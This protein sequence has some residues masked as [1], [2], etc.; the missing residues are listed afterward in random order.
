MTESCPLDLP[1]CF[2][3]KIFSGTASK[4]LA[5]EVAALLGV[6]V[7]QAIVSQ[8]ADGETNIQILQSVRG[9]DCYVIQSAHAPVN[10]R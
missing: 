4:A 5:E 6:E 3:L 10:D 1:G 9:K 2:E 7:G 8:F